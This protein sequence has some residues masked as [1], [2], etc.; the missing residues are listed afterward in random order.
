MRGVAVENGAPI[1]ITTA[2]RVMID[3]VESVVLSLV[4]HESGTQVM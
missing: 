2:H 1:A 4:V 3:E